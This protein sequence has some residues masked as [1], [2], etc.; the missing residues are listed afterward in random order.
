MY[1]QPE[2][3]HTRA[4]VRNASQASRCGASQG[5][6][7]VRGQTHE[8]A[9]ARREEVSNLTFNVNVHSFPT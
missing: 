7:V 6:D 2:H 8:A 3:P 9:L 5:H 1:V 4:V